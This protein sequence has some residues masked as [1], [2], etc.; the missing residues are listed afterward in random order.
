MTQHDHI[1]E[2]RGLW[3]QFGDFVVHRGIDLDVRRGEILSLVGGS[4]S[5]KTTMLRQMLGLERPARGE[6]RIFGI[7]LHGKDS[8]GLRKLRERW[9]MLFQE[10]AL[11]SALTVY[12][13]IALP[14][15]STRR[16]IRSN[17]SMH[18]SGYLPT[19]VSPLN[20]IASASSNTAF[21]TS[22]TSARV[23]I[24]A[25]IEKSFEGGREA[26]AHLGVP[27][28][29]LVCIESMEGNE[30]VIKE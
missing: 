5:G 13:N 7:D 17:T 20:M 8:V 24:G 14:L 28:E 11:F 9:G 21:D 12:E 18:F 15:R 1:I 10:G 26:L 25:L 3:T 23:G 19:V 2:I 30:I 27:I 22:V 6:V 16:A 29:T 4:G